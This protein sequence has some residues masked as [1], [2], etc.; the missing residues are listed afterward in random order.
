MGIQGNGITVAVVDTGVDASIGDLKE[1]IITGYNA[2]TGGTNLV[3]TSDLNGHGTQVA[4]LIAGNGQG[5]GLL[6]VAPGAKILPV[7]VCGG[8]V[9]S[10]VSSV[11]AGIRWAA[12]NGAKIIN[13]S[14]VVSILDP[15]LQ[16]AVKY[17]QEKGCLIIAAAGNH[18]DEEESNISYPASLPGV[19]AV[20]AMTKDYKIATFSNTGA[21]FNLIAPGTKI[22]T[23]R[24]GNS[25]TNKFVLGEGT[26]MAAPFVSGVAALIW[27]AHPDWSAQQVV[28]NIEQS[29]Q[30][31]DVTGHSYQAF[32]VPDAYRAMKIAD[33]QT[34][35]PSAKINHYLELLNRKTGLLIDYIRLVILTVLNIALITVF[36]VRKRKVSNAIGTEPLLK[37][38]C[39]Y[40]LLGLFV[41]GLGLKNLYYF[42]L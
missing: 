18:S 24:I 6:G 8:S 26:S 34:P 20:T 42:F 38:S 31:L 9:D 3:D 40:L 7:K 4:S 36:Y 22:L 39:A 25:S 16:E 17:A 12:D 33:P 30:R 11:Q 19:V 35:P 23:A 28:S 27:S 21:D 15:Q 5:L 37:I 32:S 41:L 29:A 2:I 14:I 10:N 13:L 1:N